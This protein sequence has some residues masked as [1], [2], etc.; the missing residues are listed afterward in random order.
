MKKIV[1]V[2][3]LNETLLSAQNISYIILTFIQE[4][5]HCAELNHGAQNKIVF[6]IHN[7]L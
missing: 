4:T 2:P 3:I 5:V 1:F 7:Y 6:K